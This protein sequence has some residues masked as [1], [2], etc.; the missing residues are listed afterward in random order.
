VEMRNCGKLEKRNEKREMKWRNEMVTVRG[1]ERFANGK[2]EKAG[3]AEKM[4]CQFQLENT[5]AGCV[6]RAASP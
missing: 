1:V 4:V 5:I 2:V 3:K 6:A